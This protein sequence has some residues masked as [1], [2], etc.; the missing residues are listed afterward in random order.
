[1]AMSCIANGETTIDGQVCDNNTYINPYQLI[2]FRDQ[3][4]QNPSSYAYHLLNKPKGIECTLNQDV[5]N[6]L[7][8]LLPEPNLFYAGRLDKNST[9]LV[10]LTNDGHIYNQIIDPKKKIDKVYEVILEKDHT[11]SFLDEMANGVTILGKLTLPCTVEPID[12]RSFK[13]TLTQGL[14][15]QIRRMCFA[16]GN[17]VLELKRIQIGI[18]HLEGIETGNCRLLTP[19]EIDWLRNLPV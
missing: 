2:V 3:I 8:S 6:N 14:N 7:I 15:R 10:L 5:P 4:I 9:G 13:I 11:Q 18:L 19:A 12:S 17:Y 1:M 16:L